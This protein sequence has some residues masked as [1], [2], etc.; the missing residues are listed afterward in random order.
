[1]TRNLLTLAAGGVLAA[2]VGAQSPAAL[3]PDQRGEL[4][5]MNRPVIE[6]LIDETVEGSRSPNDHLK[7][8]DSYYQVLREFSFQIRE[9][10]KQGNAERVAELTGHLTAL[11]DQGLAP[12]LVKAKRQVEGGSGQEEFPG[13]RNNLVAQI[14]ALLEQLKE[15]SARASLEGA[16]SKVNSI[17]IPEK[18]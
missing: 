1:M 4:Y 17:T 9:A 16:R 18:K 12:S 15:P 5:R 2:L 13:T 11:V 10:E 3:R 14:N 6:R 8:A 7:R